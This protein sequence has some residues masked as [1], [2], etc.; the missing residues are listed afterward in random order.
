[1]SHARTFDIATPTNNN[2]T[3]DGD[4]KIV[5]NQVDLKQR[6]EL[7]HNMDGILNTALPTADGY[8]KKVTMKALT[9]AAEH[10]TPL[11][12]SG[13]IYT[14][15]VDGIIELFFKE[16]STG[17]ANQLTENGVINLNTLQNDID[18]NGKDITGLDNVTGVSATITTI[19]GT[20]I[21]G[22]TIQ[23][24]HKS[25]DGT[26]GATI[27]SEWINSGEVNNDQLRFIYK[28]GLLTS[29]GRRY[30]NGTSWVA[31]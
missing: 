2:F 16:S 11:T 7:D 31:Y 1:M 3:G 28:N 12:G 30:F 29:I 21:T 19:N 20:T 23:G 9:Q 10:P 6:L 26:S 17:V 15:E 13:V 18:G 4:D 24:G 22:T 27:A 8:H 5:E 25:S 14:K